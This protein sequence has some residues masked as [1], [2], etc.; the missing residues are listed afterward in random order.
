MSFMQCQT[1]FDSLCTDAIPS[2]ADTC[3]G[4]TLKEQLCEALYAEQRWML[5]LVSNKHR[6]ALP[7]FF[8]F[9]ILKLFFG[10]GQTLHA[11]LG[12]LY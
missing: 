11:L 1:H 6:V 8:F 10:S 3:G 9:A 12:L 5:Y 4:V 7:F 2:C